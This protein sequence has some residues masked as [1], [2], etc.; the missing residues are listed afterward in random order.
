MFSLTSYE[1]KALL[2]I[3]V[4]IFCG[5]LLRVLNINFSRQKAAQE[6]KTKVSA[7]IQ[8]HNVSTKQTIININSASQEELE[9]LP[10]IGPDIAS[11]I[12]EYRQ[13]KG[14]FTMLDNLRK[15]K[16]IGVK[17]LEAIRE[18]ISF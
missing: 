9:K 14:Q 10:G 5:T 17:K 13:N 4:V 15:V 6:I 8:S 3:A 7:N 11:R 16:G 18:Y 2:L 1:R 12:I